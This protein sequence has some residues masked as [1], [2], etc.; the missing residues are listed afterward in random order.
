MSP[1]RSGSCRAASS[2]GAKRCGEASTAAD[3]DEDE[4]A[5]QLEAREGVAEGADGSGGGGG[6]GDGGE[7]DDAYEW[8]AEMDPRPRDVSAMGEDEHGVETAL[9]QRNNQHQRD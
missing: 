5:A 3:V 4:E 8:A 7:E 1:A 2:S 6:P 9:K